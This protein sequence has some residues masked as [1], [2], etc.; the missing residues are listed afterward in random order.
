VRTNDLGSF[1]DDAI[2]PSDSNTLLSAEHST[3]HGHSSAQH[4]V[5]QSVLYRQPQ[6]SEKKDNQ[7]GFANREVADQ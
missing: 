1:F 2:H 3:L 5:S 4:D 6:H 7:E